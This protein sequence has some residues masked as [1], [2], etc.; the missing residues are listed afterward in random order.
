LVKHMNEAVNEVRVREHKRLLAAGDDTLKN[1]RQ[2][3][4]YGIENVPAKHAQRFD[5][6]KELN[7]QTSRAWAIKEVFRSFWLCDTVKKAERYFYQWYGW[8]IRSR[9]EPVK[10]VARM[11]K[12]HL[13]N[14]LTYFVHRLTNGRIEGLNNAI[15]GLIKKAFGYRNKDRFKTEI[16][17]HYG[18][19]DL[20]PAQ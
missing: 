18:R 2:L 19:L 20:Y 9:L 12:S 16:F 14:V 11:C 15:Q 10:K 7:L 1:T 13:G 3:W 17:F 4:L 5:E 6:V 8:A